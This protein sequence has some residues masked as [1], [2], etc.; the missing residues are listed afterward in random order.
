VVTALSNI[1][2]VDPGEIALFAGTVRDFAMEN[3][4]EQPSIALP[5]ELLG[6]RHINGPNSLD[7]FD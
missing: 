6:M 4:P 3:E 1:F 5:N 7:F 2:R